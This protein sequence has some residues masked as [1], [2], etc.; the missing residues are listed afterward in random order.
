MI[1]KSGGD[2]RYLTLAAFAGLTLTT[3][4][5][6]AEEAVAGDAHAAV[7]GAQLVAAGGYEAA[8][9]AHAPTA[10]G[11][12][13]ASEAHA[14]AAGGHAAEAG[15]AHGP[16]GRPEFHADR[17]HHLSALV[18][19]TAEDGEAGLTFGVDYEY[20]LGTR[21]GVG[22]VAEYAGGELNATTLLAVADLHLWRGLAL[23]TG[24]GV[25][26]IDREEEELELFV[27]RV[28]FLYEFEFGRFTVSPQFHVDLV[29]KGETDA[30]VSAIA[31]GFAF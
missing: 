7:I 23:Q 24:P 1:R 29:P 11:G 3:S 15:E 9:E 21:L 22:A 30:F 20:R 26:L 6:V 19:S 25:E 5:A 16:P 18:G 14:E 8:S 4:P 10:G 27:Y 28:G 12:E 2:R 31:F 13:A 17:P